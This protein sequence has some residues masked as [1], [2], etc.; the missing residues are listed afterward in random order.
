MR[1]WILWGLTLSWL[2]GCAGVQQDVAS[3]KLQRDLRNRLEQQNDLL[4][5]TDGRLQALATLVE[6]MQWRLESVNAPAPSVLPTRLQLPDEP[7]PEPAPEWSSG[8]LKLAETLEERMVSA[9]PATLPASEL[10]MS[11]LGR[12]LPVNRFLSSDGSVLDLASYQGS[13][14]VVLVVLRGFSG[15]ICLN[16]SVQTRA[17]A[18]SIEEFSSRDTQVLLVYPGEARSVPQFLDAVSDLGPDFVLPF[19][20][21]LDLDFTFVRSARLEG[22][23]A[24]PSSFILDSSGVVRYAY[25]G[26]NLSDRPSLNDLL[27]ALDGIAE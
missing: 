25:I 16:C 18:R 8:E 7:E 2:A 17:L 5:L 10:S 6:E 20:V 27:L 12:R 26:K 11:W 3:A 24:K 4:Q 9:E 19:P 1:R 13:K 14:R 21:L 15:Q 23:L 22:E